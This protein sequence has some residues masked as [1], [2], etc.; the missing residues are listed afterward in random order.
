MNRK[1][2]PDVSG[3]FAPNVLQLDRAITQNPC[4]VPLNL[5]I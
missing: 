5:E 3:N 4:Y 2:L 1:L